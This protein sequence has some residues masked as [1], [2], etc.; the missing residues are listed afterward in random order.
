MK[1]AVT[2]AAHLARAFGAAMAAAQEDM[3]ARP[4]AV[5][6]GL[7]GVIVMMV[8]IMVVPMRMIM[9]MPVRVIVKAVPVGVI[10]RHG[11]QFS[12]KRAQNRPVNVP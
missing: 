5:V 11:R 9:G 10:V 1:T 2:I 12:A 8:M 4:D 6:M 7:V 3:V